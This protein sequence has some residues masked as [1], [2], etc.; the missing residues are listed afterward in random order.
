MNKPRKRAFT[1]GAAI[2]LSFSMLLPSC[3]I[4]SP[5]APEWDVNLTVPLVNRVY[6]S[7]ELLEELDP[8]HIVSDSAGNSF[9]CVVEEL[10]TVAIDST[11]ALDPVSTSYDRSVG[12]IKIAT[13][14]PQ[15]YQIAMADNVPLIAGAVP[16]TGVWTEQLLDQSNNYSSVDIAEGGLIVTAV[17]N[18]G[19]DLD[20]VVFELYDAQTTSLLGSYVQ[21]G[22]LAVA[23]SLLDTLPLAGKSVSADF[24]A[25]TYFHTPGGLLLSLAERSLDLTFSFTNNLAAASVTGQVEQFTSDYSQA[26]E[27]NTDYRI[28]SA[29]LAEGTLDFSVI[30]HLPLPLEMH[31]EFPEISNG[32][33]AFTVELNA[34]AGAQADISRSLAGFTVQ[35]V[36]NN[37]RAEIAATV[38]SSG[39]EFVTIAQDDNI[40]FDLDLTNLKIAQARAVVTPTEVGWTSTS[41]AVDAPEGF[42]NASFE[43]VTLAL[44]ISNGS[45]LPAD[46]Q[47]SLTADHGAQVA[48][49]GHVIPGSLRNPTEAII[50]SSDLALLLS[51]VPHSI[52]VAGV[53]VVGD[54]ITPVDISESDFLTATAELSA[55]L[56]LQ[57]AASSF[58]GDKER[59]EIEPDVRERVDRLQAGIFHGTMTNHLPLGASVTIYIAVDSA[60]LFSDPLVTIGPIAFD[61]GIVGPQGRVV[62]DRVTESTLELTAEQ[63]GVFANS[64]IY[65]APVISTPGSDGKFIKIRAQ[66]YLDMAGYVEI[67]ARVGGEDL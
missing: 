44:S 31:I 49:S 57:L 25:A 65:V 19:L 23:E 48:V 66:D 34:A 2:L 51:P 5:Q 29:S 7:A 8:E 58:E 12:P 16:D 37:I 62:T 53:A 28:E 15:S 27:L 33:G 14:A 30:N 21:P 39:D 67:T 17:N 3:S 41:I 60:T 55:P 45:E 63:I 4:E 54:G 24:R 32:A 64:T 22:G 1:I 26:T 9:F 50:T 52:T 18:T 36:D 61:Q 56:D 43:E 10:D 46:L 40:A 59:V 47:I 20:S 11:L 13:P 38:I 42:D 35:P 6:T